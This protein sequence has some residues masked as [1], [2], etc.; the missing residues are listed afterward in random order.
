VVLLSVLSGRAKISQ[1]SEFYGGAIAEPENFYSAG[2]TILQRDL[3]SEDS[4][5]LTSFKI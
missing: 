5:Q 2:K 1:G 4:F 3:F